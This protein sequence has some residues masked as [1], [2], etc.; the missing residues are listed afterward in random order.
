MMCGTCV[1]V[2][3][4]CAT[5]ERCFILLSFHTTT[6]TTTTATTN[7]GK[8][9]TVD[10]RSSPPH[11]LFRLPFILV[12]LPMDPRIH[13][14]MLPLYPHRWHF[15]HNVRADENL[16][17]SPPI[18]VVAAA[19][20]SAAALLF[21]PAYLPTHTHTHRFRPRLPIRHLK[22]LHVHTDV[23]SPIHPDEQSSPPTCPSIHLYEHFES[24]MVSWV[25]SIAVMV[26]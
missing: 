1:C 8:K 17:L 22:T 19:G 2:C 18:R 25:W 21:F 5:H 9:T 13:F 3:M 15:P 24:S 6:T 4:Q 16:S 20:K 10:Y 12:V 14:I 11:T 7:L 26:K 23:Y